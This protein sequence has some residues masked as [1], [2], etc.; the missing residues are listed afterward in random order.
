MPKIAAGPSWARVLTVELA[1]P[2]P[3]GRQQGAPTNG[4]EK[5]KRV[6]THADA[7]SRACK[8]LRSVPQRGTKRTLEQ[9]FEDA[10]GR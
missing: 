3:L 2:R 1:S 9:T 8:R 5:K 6:L 7:E 10:A 4:G